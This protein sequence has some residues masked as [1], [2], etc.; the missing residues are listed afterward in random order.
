MFQNNKPKVRPQP[1]VTTQRLARSFE[2][3]DRTDAT[4]FDGTIGSIDHRLSRARELSRQARVLRAQTDSDDLESLSVLTSR[5]DSLTDTVKTLESVKVEYV[6]TTHQEAIQSLPTYTV[7][8][9][10]TRTQALGEERHGP[11]KLAETMEV[12]SKYWEGFSAVE[13]GV[14]LR[15]NL[16]ALASAGEIRARAADYVGEKTAGLV[17]EQ[18]RSQLIEDFVN[19]VERLRRQKSTTRRRTAKAEELDL[20]SVNDSSLFL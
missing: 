20:S 13:P 1:V 14:F 9:A 19:N 4:W 7:M 6:E 3:Y 11:W 16:D 10:N 12:D 2:D 18:F 15:M 17:N 8:A 5:I